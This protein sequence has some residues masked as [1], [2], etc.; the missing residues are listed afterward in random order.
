MR[1]E[2]SSIVWNLKRTPN[3]ASDSVK[4]MPD[5]IS[6]IRS[7]LKRTPKS[8]STSIKKKC[9]TRSLVLLEILSVLLTRLLIPRLIPE[10][11]AQNL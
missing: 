1:V 10:N 9:Q 11:V 5:E 6:S 8:A 2:I 3:S 7:D 4:K